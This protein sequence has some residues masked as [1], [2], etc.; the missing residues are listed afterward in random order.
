[1]AAL[2]ERTGMA[3]D[4]TAYEELLDFSDPIPIILEPSKGYRIPTD[5]L[6]RNPDGASAGYWFPSL[7]PDRHGHPWRGPQYLGQ[8][9]ASLNCAMIFDEFYSTT[10]GSMLP[11]WGGEWLSM[12]KMSIETSL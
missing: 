3:L 4:Y 10:S 9:C 2:T 6:V 11:S 7:Q 5:T 12:S 1:M 8:D